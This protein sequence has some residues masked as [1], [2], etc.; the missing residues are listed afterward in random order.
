[1]TATEFKEKYPQHKN[2]EGDELWDKMTTT[3]LQDGS[4]LYAD[5]KQEKVWLDTIEIP[6]LQEDGSYINIKITMEDSS[7]TRW[8]DKE[9]KLV[10]V[11]EPLLDIP[12]NPVT[13]HSIVIWDVTDNINNYE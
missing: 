9:G 10:R 6:T 2:L 5:P 8:L 13:S 11:G 7:T 3:F 4:V 12:Q 1:M